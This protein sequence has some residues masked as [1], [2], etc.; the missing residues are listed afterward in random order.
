MARKLTGEQLFRFKLENLGLNYQVDP[1]LYGIFKENEDSI[2]DLNN[3]TCP[4]NESF[5]FKYEDNDIEIY[6]E[7]RKNYTGKYIGEEEIY[8]IRCY[9]DRIRFYNGREW[10]EAEIGVWID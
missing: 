6:G 3:T 5:D 7:Y 2:E 8:N 9:I 1:L 10:A 4:F